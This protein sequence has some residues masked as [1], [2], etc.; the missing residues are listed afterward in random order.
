MEDGFERIL[1]VLMQALGI[2]LEE[3]YSCFSDFKEESAVFVKSNFPRAGRCHWAS[4]AEACIVPVAITLFRAQ[5]LHTDGLGRPMRRH[6]AECILRVQFTHSSA[7][8]WWTI[9]AGLFVED[10][11]ASVRFVLPGRIP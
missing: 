5:V 4:M 6:V 10:Q 7:I 3:G 2:D 8:S 9:S 11:S 1:R